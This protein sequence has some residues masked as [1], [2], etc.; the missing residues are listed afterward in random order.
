LRRQPLVVHLIHHHDRHYLGSQAA[1]V[2]QLDAVAAQL[3]GHAAT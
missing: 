3:G 2:H 1:L